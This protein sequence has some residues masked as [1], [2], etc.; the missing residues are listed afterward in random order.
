VAQLEDKEEKLKETVLNILAAENLSLEVRC[1]L[2]R[3]LSCNMQFRPGI[4]LVTR[5][6]SW[7]TWR[8]SRLDLPLVVGWSHCDGF[9]YVKFASAN[10]II[11]FK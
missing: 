1:C 7:L 5:H 8:N 4:V 2:A 11:A 6:R 10:A 9:V 3:P